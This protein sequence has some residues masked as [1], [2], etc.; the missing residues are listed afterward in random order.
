M[1]ALNISGAPSQ[2][3]MIAVKRFC[4][5]S[6]NWPAV[7]NTLLDRGHAESEGFAQLRKTTRYPVN[8]KDAIGPCVPV[9]FCASR[10]LAIIWFVISVIVFAFYR[11]S[12]R[13][14]PHIGKKIGKRLPSFTNLNSSPTVQWVVASTSIE[15]ANP[16]TI[17]FGSDAV[18]NRTVSSHS[19]CSDFFSEAAT[20]HGIPCD[21]IIIDHSEARSAVAKTNTFGT[22]A[23]NG[24]RT[25]NDKPCKSGIRRNRFSCTHSIGSF[26]VVFSGG[27]AA[28]TV[29]PSRLYKITVGGQHH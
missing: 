23:I 19:H 16:A 5:C 27:R 17:C 2:G 14:F 21:Q 29:R 22:T 6:L 24:C 7:T 11:Q 20:R 25:H 9:L 18:R 10:P 26:N 1:R 28:S 13:T 12:R 4:E 3:D 8:G 15:H